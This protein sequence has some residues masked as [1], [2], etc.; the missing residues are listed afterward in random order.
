[1]NGQARSDLAGEEGRKPDPCCAVAKVYGAFLQME[2]ATCSDG[3]LPRKTKEL[4]A[5][6]I[7]VP[8]NCESCMQ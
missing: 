6:G 8:I 5:V 7:G 4:V 2:R 3:A 1:M